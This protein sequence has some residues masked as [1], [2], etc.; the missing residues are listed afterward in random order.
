V[1]EA[2]GQDVVM[3]NGMCEEGADWMAF[4]WAKRVAHIGVEEHP[5]DW[6]RRPRMAGYFRNQEMVDAGADIC[7]A[8]LLKCDRD[9]RDCWRLEEHWTHGTDHCM[10]AAAKAGIPVRKVEG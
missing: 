8:F 10:S 3:I 2:A 1:A 4:K 7:V 5:A 6:R 9:Q